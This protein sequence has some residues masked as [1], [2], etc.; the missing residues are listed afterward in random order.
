MSNP[1]LHRFDRTYHALSVGRWVVLL[2]VAFVVLFAVWRCCRGH[3]EQQLESTVQAEVRPNCNRE[4]VESFLDRHGIRNYYT[5]DFEN[6][7]F[8]GQH[9]FQYVNLREQDLSG[10]VVGV[11]SGR[12]VRSGFLEYGIIY[13][14]FFFDKRGQLIGHW[15][16]R[17]LLSL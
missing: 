5:E 15:I 4:E 16:T 7:S 10:M 13:M 12:E 14:Y 6:D 8:R 9:P 3:T 11:L 1:H 2:L 17:V